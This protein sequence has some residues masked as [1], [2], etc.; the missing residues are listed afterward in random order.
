MAICSKG[1]VGVMAWATLRVWGMVRDC[2][3]FGIRIPLRIRSRET[4]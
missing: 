1:C 2:V 3:R 4:D